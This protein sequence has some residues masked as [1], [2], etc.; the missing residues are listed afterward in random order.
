M[1]DLEAT[2]R[3][4]KPGAE[5]VNATATSAADPAASSYS[6]RLWIAGHRLGASMA[7]LAA[8]AGWEEFLVEKR[9]AAEQNTQEILK[10]IQIFAH[11]FLASHSS[12]FS[13]LCFSL[14]SCLLIAIFF[15]YSYCLPHIFIPFFFIF[16]KQFA[17]HFHFIFLYIGKFEMNI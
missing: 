1:Q 4:C 12:I 17:T 3:R 2:C 9:K 8:C 10:G 14:F 15:A 13:C 6:E 7:L 5:S 16:A 11:S